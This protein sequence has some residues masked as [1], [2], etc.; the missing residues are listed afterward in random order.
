MIFFPD[1]P[2]HATSPSR[3]KWTAVSHRS[4][5]SWS[6]KRLSPPVQLLLVSMICTVPVIDQFC[7]S[8]CKWFRIA[9]LAVSVCSQGFQFPA[10]IVDQLVHERWK[11][12]IFHR[13]RLPRWRGR[14]NLIKIGE[15]SLSGGPS[16][17]LDDKWSPFRSNG[18][19]WKNE[20]Q[21]CIP[22]VHCT[23]LLSRTK[24][25]WNSTCCHEFQQTDARVSAT[26]GAFQQEQH[27]PVVGRGRWSQGVLRQAGFCEATLMQQYPSVG[28]AVPVCARGKPLLLTAPAPSRSSVEE[29]SVT[30]GASAQ[31]GK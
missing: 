20:P 9:Q 22:A 2:L 23:L 11:N 3:W 24:T 14:R 18:S 1:V 7:D 27:P 8:I 25:G 31:R 6:I 17:Q 4:L 28:L 13:S 19:F 30:P 21:P 15:V 10:A 29:H 16:N 12:G 26:R 5:A